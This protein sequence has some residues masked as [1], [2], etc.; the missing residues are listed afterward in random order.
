MIQH[1][2]KPKRRIN[3]KLKI[4]RLYYGKYRLPGDR[5]INV[6]ALAVSDKQVAQEKLKQI[7]SEQE[8]E[9]V[10][11]IAPKKIRDSGQKALNAHV[12]D[13]IA[14]LRAVDTVPSEVTL[15][16]VQLPVSAT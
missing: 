13:F 11:L 7:V 5:K 2:F 16:I 6:V 8:R 14:D 10:G 1:V 15:R 12:E 3:G 4:S 9:T